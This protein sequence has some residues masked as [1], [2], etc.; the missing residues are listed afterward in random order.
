MARRSAGGLILELVYQ[1]RRSYGP[2]MDSLAHEIR[3]EIVRGVILTVLIKHRLEWITFGSLRVQ[4]QRGQGYSLEENELRFHLAY[5]GDSTRGYVENKSL[6]ASCWTAALLLIPAC[7]SS[8]DALQG[9][10]RAGLKSRRYVRRV[11]GNGTETQKK[12]AQEERRGSQPGRVES[13][14]IGSGRTRPGK[15][16]YGAQAPAGVF[17]PGHSRL[18]AALLAVAREA[19]FPT[20]IEAEQDAASAAPVVR[21]FASTG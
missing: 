15:R 8:V 1:P 10:R 21:G 9:G 16:Q 14:G 4:V 12:H 20:G 17:P 5:L 6:R 13:R 18:A 19:C 7:S 2:T 3:D 11:M